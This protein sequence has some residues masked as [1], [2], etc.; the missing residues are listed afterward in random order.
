MQTSTAPAL[1]RPS[2]R[3]KTRMGAA[4][5][6]L[7]TLIIAGWAYLDWS[8]YH[9]A[10]ALAAR[11]EQIVDASQALLASLLDAETGQRGFLLTGEEQYLEPYNRASKNI[12]GQLTRLASLVGPDSAQ[13]G[14]VDSLRRLVAQKASELAQTIDLRRTRG[15]QAALNEVLSDRGRS[16]MDQ[17]RAL[18][19]TIQNGERGAAIAV[20]TDAEAATMIV[21]VVTVAGALCLFFFVMSALDPALPGGRREVKHP[22]ITAYGTALA[23]TAI[24]L[25]LRVALSP[26]IAPLQAPFITFFPAVL[27]ASWYAG[28]RSGA[29]T[30]L[31]L[32]G[33][34][35][36]FAMGPAGMSWTDRRSSG[37]GLL[38]FMLVGA[39]IVLLAHSQRQAIERADLEAA[40]RRR[41]EEAE[42]HQ[43][44]QYEIT[45]SS[46]GDAV[47]V[48]DT[49]GRITFTNDVA[50]RILRY[51]DSQ[52]AGRPFEEV[53]RICNEHTRAP[54]ESPVD[55]VLRAGTGGLANHTILIAGDGTEV[56]LDDSGAPVR[57]PDGAIT[58]VVLVFRDISERR[59]A[60]KQLEAQSAILR[61]SETL[62]RTL[63]NALPQLVCMAKPDG[64]V[65]W[66]NDRWS[67]YT[68]SSPEELQGWGWQSVHDPAMLPGILR[69]WHLSLATGTPFE[70]VFPIRGKDGQYRPFL[71]RVIPL[72]DSDGKIVRWIGTNTDVSEQLLIEQRL[73]KSEM[74][75][76]RLNAELAQ[77]NADLQQFAF[78]A[79]H[80][81]QEPLRVVTSFVQLLARKYPAQTDE[82]AALFTGQ[83]LDATA[84]MRTLL[85]DLL[86]YAEIGYR[87]EHRNQSADL[88][89]VIAGVK[90][91]L[92]D[93]IE[94]SGAVIDCGRLPTL[95]ADASYLIP[96]FQNLLSN[97]IKY[98]GPKPPHI[99]ITTQE[100]NG[101]LRFA[102]ADNGVGID[103]EY[104][105][106]IFDVF[107]RL[108]GRDVPGSGLGL[109]ICKRVVERYGGRIWV[110]S[111][112]GAGATFYF[113]LPLAKV[114]ELSSYAGETAHS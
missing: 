62:F 90:Q 68:G 73:R 74:R 16:T 18:I 87:E 14:N 28:A 64:W 89:A 23:V 59:A 26:M 92:N 6:I 5:L 99:R 51:P 112:T 109:S 55:Q 32:A 91:N 53:F 107:Q 63:A 105:R 1:E 9:A 56:P 108:H 103:P 88:R 25:L 31:L 54:V 15:A 38:F 58:G 77:S 20:S 60:E 8:R 70:M 35:A 98:R 104:H 27:M 22:W 19:L 45:L 17:I 43:R 93:A 4:I 21:L 102:V 96:L 106:K 67:Q 34:S 13:S 75:L 71:T 111:A 36:W 76:E 72:R 83:I 44:Q 11:S 46:I 10:N 2:L 97:A 85:T 101:E 50:R 66:Y 47:V 110:E 48:T 94:R 95:Q 57:G 33:I 3:K 30:L 114:V 24:A 80:D 39:G 78:V 79:S 29:A 37:I 52:L 65:F 12:P 61:E 49:H 42:K 86:Q 82:E 81:L 41:A 7:V 113:T 40:R 84:R 100:A 69:Q